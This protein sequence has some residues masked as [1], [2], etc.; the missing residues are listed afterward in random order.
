MSG[1]GEKPF[2]SSQQRSAGFGAFGS[3]ISDS[4]RPGGFTFGS[5]TPTST[6]SFD[7]TIGSSYGTS[8][9]SAA[10]FGTRSTSSA[11]SFPPVTTTTSTPG[12]FASSRGNATNIFGSTGFGGKSFGSSAMET[13]FGTSMSPSTTQFGSNVPIGF[14]APTTSEFGAPSQ[15]FAGWAW[16]K[17]AL[18]TSKQPFS[19]FVESEL[20]SRQKSSYQNLCFQGP[21]KN[22]SQE[23]LRLADYALGHRYGLSFRFSGPSFGTGFGTS[24]QRSASG[25]PQTF[26]MGSQQGAFGTGFGAKS[27]GATGFGSITTTTQPFGQ[28]KAGET[29][30]WGQ[31]S[32][33]P[34]VFGTQL[35][36]FQ[37]P[38]SSQRDF[39]VSGGPGFGFAQRPWYGS[40]PQESRTSWSSPS[41]FQ[42]LGQ[43]QVQGLT[44][45]AEAQK[46][47]SSQPP[48]GSIF[49]TDLSTAPNPFALAATQ[50]SSLS[51]PSSTSQRPWVTE[52]YAT[53]QAGQLAT[54]LPSTE[55]PVGRVQVPQ[56][57]GQQ[58]Q[59]R[60]IGTPYYQVPGRPSSDTRLIQQ[61]TQDATR[62]T[63]QPQLVAKIDEIT[64]YG[65]PW[66][67]LTTEEKQQQQDRGPLAV[68]R[69]SKGKPRSQSVPAGFSFRSPKFAPRYIPPGSPRSG[70]R[71][72]LY[73]ASYPV[74]RRPLSSDW[75][76]PP[77]ISHELVRSPS[78]GG[79]D[80]LRTSE[81]IIS[82]SGHKKGLSIVEKSLSQISKKLKTLEINQDRGRDLFMS[83]SKQ[84]GQKESIGMMTSTGIIDPGREGGAK[85]Q[86]P[87]TTTESSEHTSSPPSP[88]NTLVISDHEADMEEIKSMKARRP[89]PAGAYWIRPS[90]EDILAMNKDQ[91]KRVTDLTIGR[92]N[93]GVIH[94]KHPVDFTGIDL[95][96][97]LG[98]LVILESRSATVYPDS[99]GLKPPPGEGF[100]V[101]ALISLENS[102]PRKKTN[103]KG[104]SEEEAKRQVVSHIERLK[105][106]EGTR[107]ES[108]SEEDGTWTFS[109]DH[110][111]TY[112]QPTYNS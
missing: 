42:A 86:T 52:R 68:Q 101:P 94:F 38:L 57:F 71:H 97:L 19:P 107:F 43:Q 92:E 84:R 32:Q 75:M 44:S 47:S 83:S 22:S 59:Y 1:F 103:G 39:G 105:S 67:F 104:L 106:V 79:F 45:F 3:N 28:A 91:R 37:K 90:K 33:G 51:G 54:Q 55:M 82:T 102:W 30:V 31:K 7:A 61:P 40:T 109:V 14:R 49:R 96:S 35:D 12:I 50:A 4:S 111:S 63:I 65:A 18:D 110:F 77:D 81:D 24:M 70:F 13:D 11:A 15:P 6:G 48:T 29:L 2:G 23:E 95:E 9:G 36:G 74:K 10:S 64:A 76:H 26:G 20:G 25:P 80:Q 8:G 34:N 56:S 87:G 93:V 17:P 53:T 99:F 88:G 73:D 66:L 46:P 85:S 72:G 58:T 62:A 5:G 89:I 16:G 41:I 27:S 100:N 21:Y 98:G 60:Q 112:N 69:A 108:Y 78:T